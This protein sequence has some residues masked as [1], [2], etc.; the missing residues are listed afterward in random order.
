MLTYRIDGSKVR[1]TGLRSLI[2]VSH[3]VRDSL[4]LLSRSRAR[5]LSLS[6]SLSSLSISLSLSLSLSAFPLVCCPVVDVR[7]ACSSCSR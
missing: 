6:L 1:T 4:S 2:V 5:A 3:T 7:L